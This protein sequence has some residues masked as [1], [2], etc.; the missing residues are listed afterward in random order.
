MDTWRSLDQERERLDITIA[1]FYEIT[2]LP[3]ELLVSSLTSYR[4]VI[5]QGTLCY[6]FY[7][8]PRSE[9]GAADPSKA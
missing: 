7:Y 2:S 5:L 4:T 9:N 3:P 1:V 8:L 6:N